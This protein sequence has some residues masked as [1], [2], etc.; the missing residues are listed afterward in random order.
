M[1]KTRKQ[2]RDKSSQKTAERED[3]L[4]C[5]PVHIFVADVKFKMA[6]MMSL[7]QQGKTRKDKNKK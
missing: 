1:K 2:T 5:L 7:R 4:A 3:F 6:F